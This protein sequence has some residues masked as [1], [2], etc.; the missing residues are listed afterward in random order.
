MGKDRISELPEDLLLKIL[1]SLPTKTV[2]ATSVLSKRWLS[3]WKLVPKLEFN[4]ENSRTA[5]NIGRSLLL[6][7]APVLESLHLTGLCDDIDVGLWAGIAFARN[8]REFVLQVWISFSLPVRFPSSLLFCDTLDTLKLKNP[9]IQ[10][11]LP[12]PVSMKSLRTLHLD[13]VTYK[14]DESICNLLSGCPNLEDLLVHRACPINYV[15]NFIIVVPSLKR[16]WLRDRIS[17]QD[18]GGYVINAPSLK[19]LQIEKLKSYEHCLIEDAPELVEANI[20]NISKIVNEKIMGSLKSAKRLSLDLSPLKIKCPAGVIFYQLIYLEMYTHKAEWWNL[21]TIMLES[22][23][24]LQVLKLIDQKQDFSK[25][26]VVGGKWKKPKRVPKCLLSHLET[27]V[28]KKYDWRRE[29]EK[30]VATYILRNARCL[31]KATFS[32]RPIDWKEKLQM[33]N[34]MNGVVKASDSCHLVFE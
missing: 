17:G 28:W 22:S 19:Y 6:H 16:L 26:G 31:K 15:K 8:V 24:K 12:S 9:P 29:E 27:F 2:I 21:L 18:I 3:L 34:E 30:G 13:S 7:K 20:S 32:T 10:I 1:S 14:N 5:E 23:P 33:L 11:D 4:S 25:D